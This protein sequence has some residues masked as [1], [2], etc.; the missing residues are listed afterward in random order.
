METPA[1]GPGMAAVWWIRCTGGL[2]GV[3]RGCTGG[4]GGVGRGCTG[5]GT[6]VGCW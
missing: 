3:G 2:G 4:L 1:Y 5:E 6:V